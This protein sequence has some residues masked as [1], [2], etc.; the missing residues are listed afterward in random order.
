MGSS[1]RVPVPLVPRRVRWAAVGVIALAIVYFSLITVPAKPPG[2]GPLWDKQMHFAAYGGLALVMAYATVRFRSRPYLR[3]MLVIGVVALF[4]G[5]I[6]VLQGMVPYRYFS[7]WDGV[8]NFLGAFIAVAWFII[9]PYV[10][11]RPVPG[12]QD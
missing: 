8:A 12:S 11:Y 6:E 4:G 10:R 3:G 2:A 9:E 5:L 7:V 1:L